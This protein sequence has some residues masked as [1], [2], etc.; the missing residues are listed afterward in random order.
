M[1][2]WVCVLFFKQKRA[3]EM[4]IRDWSSDVCASDLY[5]PL[6]RREA[7]QQGIDVVGI[8]VEAEA[9]AQAR[10]AEIGDDVGRPQPPVQR[11]GRRLAAEIE[12]EEIGRASCR[13][14]VCQFV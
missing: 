10:S 8:V 9:D 5:S 7:L 13:E 4:R 14:R 6:Q 3:Y 12:G 11:A 2:D 1:S